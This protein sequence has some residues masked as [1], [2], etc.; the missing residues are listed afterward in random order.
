MLGQWQ[1][2]EKIVITV[3]A[4]VQWSPGLTAF[5]NLDFCLL[6]CDMDQGATWDKWTA[7]KASCLQSSHEAGSQNS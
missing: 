3:K 2:K 1:D 7:P 4:I 5:G 6:R